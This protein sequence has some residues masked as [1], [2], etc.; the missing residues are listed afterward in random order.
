MTSIWEPLFGIIVLLALAMTLGSIAERL[1]QSAIVGF[2]LAG[3]LLGPNVLGAVLGGMED[4]PGVLRAMIDPAQITAIADL[5]VTLLMFTIG[6]EFS[7]SRLRRLGVRAI[8][9]GVT[10]ITSTMAAV[11]AI[12][13]LLNLIPGVNLSVKAGV[14]LGAVFSLSS[15]GVVMPALAR[16]SEVD[17]VHGRFALGILLVQD[18]AVIPLVLV[19]AALGG[20]GTVGQVLLHT[21]GQFGIVA[22]FVAGAVL[23][24]RLVVPRVV[25]FN[26]PTG[27]REVTVLFAIVVSLGAAW[28]AN[29]LGLSPALGAFIAAIF[30]GESLIAPRLRGDVGPLKTIFVTLFFASIGMLG[31][32]V[33]IVQNLAWVA[34]ALGLLLLV[35]PTLIWATGRLFR[36]AHRHA[37]AAGVCMGQVGVF[38]FVLARSAQ[39]GGVISAAQFDLV[40]SITIL[41]LFL[42]PYLVAFAPTAGARGERLLRRWGLAK[43][44]QHEDAALNRELAGHIVVVGFGPAGRAVAHRMQR[45]G[46]TVVVVDLNPASIRAAREAGMRGVLGDATAPELLKQVHINAAEALVLTVPDHRLSMAIIVEARELAPNLQI[47][48]RSRYHRYVELLSATGASVVVDEEAHVGDRLSETLRLKVRTDSERDHDVI[49]EEPALPEEVQESSVGAEGQADPQPA[50][51]PTAS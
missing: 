43:I 28:G 46:S 16:R 3:L 33:W 32:P 5:G 31:D 19:V 18:I 12:S 45:S 14:A 26:A 8:A 50:G 20:E 2:M 24:V 38:S 34:V 25:A 35:K 17:S 1:K 6:L 39:D 30:L 23:F 49:R 29:R 21:A 11:V 4:A 41:T 10:Q 36:L 37:I 22:A 44:G 47:V 27:N 40:V 48:A 51:E 42:T 13:Q 15:T 9:T 7:W